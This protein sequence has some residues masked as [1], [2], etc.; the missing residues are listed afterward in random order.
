MARLSDFSG[1]LLASIENLPL[2]EFDSTPWAGASKLR[3]A[4]VALVSS[5]GLHRASDDNFLRGSSEYR[6]IPGDL[7]Y[8]D[9]RMSHVSANFDRTG[10]HQD[11]NVV[12]PLE[13]LRALAAEGSIGSVADWHYSF[14][15]A[16]DPERL[17]DAGAQAGRLL[18]NDGVTAALLIPV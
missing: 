3:D 12:F 11:V 4:R 1:A 13:H 6:L 5:A 10:F 18:K 2:P 14:M 8:A 16:T 7:D 9:L 15:G 17:A